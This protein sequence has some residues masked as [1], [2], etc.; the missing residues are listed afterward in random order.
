MLLLTPVCKRTAE[1]I[2]QGKKDKE[3]IMFIAT[4]ASVLDAGIS[5]THGFW[6]AAKEIEKDKEVFLIIEELRKAEQLLR[7]NASIDGALQCLSGG[8][9]EGM[10]YHFSLMVNMAQKRGGSLRDAILE[11]IHLFRE[12][13]ELE[14]EL[15]I[16]ITHKRFE[17][18]LMLL[19]VP[20]M[21]F[22]MRATSPSFY[23][24]MYD[25]A[26]GT[27][28]MTFSLLLYGF[29]AYIGFRIVGTDF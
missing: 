12:R 10:V 20:A 25:S 13:T 6:Q 16:L 14:N 8:E 18:A 4:L 11:I 2:V 5:F 7:L 15:D 1:K 26:Q 17:F 22:Y 9:N 21:I 24:C 3:F 29:S 23:T 19:L 27:L 28:M